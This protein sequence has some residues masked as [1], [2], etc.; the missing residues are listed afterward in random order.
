MKPPLPT[1]KPS[2]IDNEPSVL[3]E[4]GLRYRRMK[5]PLQTTRIKTPLPTIKGDETLRYR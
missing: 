5:C 3:D 1:K 4:E 2:V